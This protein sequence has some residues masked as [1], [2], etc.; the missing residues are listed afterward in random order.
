MDNFSK[1]NLKEAEKDIHAFIKK[2]NG[3]Q[4]IAIFEKYPHLIKG[5]QDEKDKK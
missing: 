4:L 3:L 2:F 5:I 1:Q